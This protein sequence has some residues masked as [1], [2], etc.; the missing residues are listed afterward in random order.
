MNTTKMVQ[1]RETRQPALTR[2]VIRQI[3]GRESLADV[4]RYGADAGYC[5]FT[6]YADTVA[7]AVRNRA[8]IMERLKDDANDFGCG[9][10][11]SMLAG[12]NC[13]KG[14][15]Q[16]EVADGLYN[17]RSENRTAVYNALAWYAA[18]EIARELNPDC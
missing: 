10:V 8:D 7:F 2:A 4:A 13:L 18:E 11:I 16:E 17:P 15:S 6:Y 14:M 9:G 3:G 1:I 5:G 12:F